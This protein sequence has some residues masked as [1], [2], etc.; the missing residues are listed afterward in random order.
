MAKVGDLRDLL[1]RKWYVDERLRLLV[2]ERK[3]LTVGS[4]DADKRAISRRRAYVK[5]RRVALLSEIESFRAESK[6]IKAE[7]KGV[8]GA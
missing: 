7:L 3:T 5:F 1:R 4:A 2:Q 6:Q 8:T